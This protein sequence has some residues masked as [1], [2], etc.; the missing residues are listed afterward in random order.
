MFAEHTDRFEE[1]KIKLN[2]FETNFLAFE[3][4]I[5]HEI[6]NTKEANRSPDN[7]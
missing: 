5:K 3:K 7:K 4:E 2:I 1:I 6:A